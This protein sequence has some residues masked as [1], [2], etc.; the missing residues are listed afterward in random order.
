VQASKWLKCQLLVDVE[1]LKSLFK[2]LG[3]FS[4][5]RTGCVIHAGQEKISKEAFLECYQDY[6]EALK[7][8]QMPDESTYRFY[9]SSVF[10]KSEDHVYLAPVGDNQFLV[11]L[12]KPVLQLQS[13]RMDYSPVDGKFHS[14]LFGSETMAWG[15]QFSY[16][17][18]FQDS[19]TLDVYNV[20]ESPQFPNTQLFKTLK[21]WV[22]QHTIPTPF[23][24]GEQ[25]L[26]I[27]VRLGKECLAWINHHPQ[28]AS[29]G[30]K[31]KV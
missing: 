28:L 5:Y 14:M 31:V 26:N 8:G 30:L 6:I 16:P 4:I 21:R 2:E 22:R 27:P 13:H 9:F 19:E 15:I 7:A 3:Q 20:I 18:I 11:R 24:I 10:T 23:L 17:Q 1:E 12:V 29:R 25:Q